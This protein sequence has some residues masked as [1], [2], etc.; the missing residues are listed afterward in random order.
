MDNKRQD[1]LR[2]FIPTPLATDLAVMGRRIRLETNSQLILDR[3]LE[4]LRRYQGNSCGKPEFMWRIVTEARPGITPPW[5]EISAFSEDGLRLISIGQHS[6]L[7]IDLE[8]REAVGILAQG[9]ATDE[10]GLLSP[11]LDDLFCLT[12]SALRLVPLSA[13]C[14]G[15]GEKGLLV[16]GPPNSGKTTSSYLATK[17]GLEFHSDQEVFLEMEAGKLRAWGDFLPAAFRPEALE[18]LPELQALTRPFHYRDL[19][20]YYLDKSCLESP[21]AR[22]VI[23]VCCVFLE[24]SQPCGARLALL[25]EVEVHRRLIENQLFKD[26]RRFEVQRA[27][28]FQALG[29]VPAYTLAYGSDP[30]E[31]A[32]SFC[33]ILA[34]HDLQEARR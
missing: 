7:G 22:P 6:F 8:S 34:S 25:S 30:E 3:T 28:V 12:A 18:F 1:P 10:V 14:V 29:E 16:F 26:E 13:A 31:A 9:L 20:F 2:R 27:Q 17:L 11:F 33:S 4:F 23:P 5:P 32:T 21:V 24:R 15:S 19:T